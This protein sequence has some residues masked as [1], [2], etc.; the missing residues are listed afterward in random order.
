M[1]TASSRQALKIIWAVDLRAGARLQ[2]TALQA[3]KALIKNRK[4]TIEPVYL[5]S[6]FLD[7]TPSQTSGDA[8][9][10]T[11]AAAAG[12]L[13]KIPGVS[14][15]N[16][17]KPLTTLT[18]FTRSMRHQ[19]ARLIEYARVEGADTIVVAS[20]GRKGI[21]K[22]FLGSFADS[23]MQQSEIPV[24]IVNPDWRRTSRLKNFLFPS[25]FSRESKDAFLRVVAFA[26][27]AKLQITLFHSLTLAISPEEKVL[28]HGYDD[29]K[30]TIQGAIADRE[31]LAASWAIEAKQHGVK[32]TV[33]VDAYE[34]TSVADTVLSYQKKHGGIIALASRGGDTLPLSIGRTTRAVVQ[35]STSAV[36]VL[37]PRQSAGSGTSAL[38]SAA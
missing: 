14:R 30:Q 33:S 36:W 21:K 1:A 29:Y 22:W 10:L 17:L 9:E 28:T 25:D 24:L 23:I 32:V 31:A 37:Y 5:I 13:A 27:S 8:L 38:Q 34:S 6:T 19:A 3:M 16:G 4:A 26:R 2:R 11:R 35:G 15:S 20:H 18:G 7:S 12:R